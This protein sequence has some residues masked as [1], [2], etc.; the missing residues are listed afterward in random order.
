LTN[1]PAGVAP[2]Y[3]LARFG[4]LTTPAQADAAFSNAQA[5]LIAAGGGLLLMPAEAPAGWTPRN[6]G[7]GIWLNPAPPAPAKGW[8]KGPGVTVI[9]Y[10]TGTLKLAPP[11]VT[12]LELSRTLDL[13]RGQSLPHWDYQPLLKLRNTLLNGS[14]AQ[15]GLVR[16]DTWSHNEN[17]SFDVMLWRHN[18]SQGDNYLIDAK[19][20]YM[21]DGRSDSG[22]GNS[23]LFSATVRSDTAL[24]RG[25][26]ESWNPGAGELVYKPGA[27]ADTLGSGRPLINLNP[28]KSISSGRAFVFNPGGS[29]LG[30]G[31]AVRSADAPWT[32]NVVG[33]YFAFDEPGEYVPG[34]DT[35]RRWWLIT[36]FTVLTNGVKC[37]SFQRHWWGAKDEQSVGRLYKPEHYS[38]SDEDRRGLRY[39]IAP[40]ANVYDVSQGVQSDHVNPAGCARLLRLAPGPSAGAAADFAPGDPVEQ[41]IGPDPFKPIPFRSWL[42]DAVPGLF[43]APVFDVANRGVMRH[44]VLTVDGGSGNLAADRAAQYDRNPPF[45]TMLRLQSAARSGLRFQADTREAALLFRQ[46]RL[47]AGQPQWIRWESATPVRLGVRADG[48]LVANGASVL[49]LAGKGLSDAAGL[50][51]GGA[52]PA[53]LRGL[54]LPVTEG[55]TRL[56]IMLP[57]EERDAS[58]GV[59]VRPSWPTACAVRDQTT[60]GFETEFDVPAPRNAVVNWVLFR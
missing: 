53:N 9:D 59:V 11:Q 34:G 38:P 29:L 27:K 13:P 14:N 57:K 6:N 17:Q 33:R 3:S 23:V 15:A 35:V 55:G 56:R 32:S 2:A 54:G 44:A 60:A 41:A 47:A 1:E 25:T 36:R 24:F 12:G 19:L 50:S 42:W 5:Q 46:P 16:A 7:Q 48:S 30:W 49:D 58:Y 10:R 39:I 43:P 8:G 45:H 28:A 52:S 21:G 4:P 51:G 20:A 18:F 40:G 31:G 26:V 37:L 22:N